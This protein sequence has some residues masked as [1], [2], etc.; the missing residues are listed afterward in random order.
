MTNGTEISHKYNLGTALGNDGQQW[1]ATL[2]LGGRQPVISF[3]RPGRPQYDYYMATLLNRRIEPAN[4]L[5]L[6]SGAD[7]CIDAD[8]VDGVLGA[9]LMVVPRVLGQFEVTWIADDPDLP[10]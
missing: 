9:A 10:F 5:Y 1:R 3:T 2:N 7:L 8:H 4:A 6:D